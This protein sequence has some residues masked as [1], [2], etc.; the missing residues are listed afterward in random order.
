VLVV[1]HLVMYSTKEEKILIGV[2]VFMRIA[3]IVSWGILLS[4]N[5]MT[6]VPHNRLI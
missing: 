3:F 2:N 4:R 1:N 6:L 5:N